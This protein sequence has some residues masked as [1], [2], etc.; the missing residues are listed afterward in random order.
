[1]PQDEN[2]RRWTIIGLAAFGIT[3]IICEIILT[4]MLRVAMW[5]WTSSFLIFML[6]AIAGVAAFIASMKLHL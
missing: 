4:L 2:M 1:M 6:S 3:G 5:G